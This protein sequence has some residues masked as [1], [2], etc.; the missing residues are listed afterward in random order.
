M[1]LE[2]H[3]PDRKTL[4]NAIGE[5]LHEPVH[6]DGAP[7]MTYSIGPVKVERDASITCDDTD[8][9]AALTPF[10][11]N[12]GWLPEAETNTGQEVSTTETNT[13]QAADTTET[14][15]VN[16]VSIPLSGFTPQSAANLVRLVYTRQDLLNAMTRG[17]TIFVDDEVI[18]LLSDRPPE[19]MDD[20]GTLLDSEAAV[21]MLRGIGIADGK[22]TIDFPFSE[23]RPTDWQH[24][25]KLM[26]ALADKARA[27][28]RVNARRIRP[29]DAE[30]KYFCN[31]LLNQLGFG[32]AEHKELRSVLL[33][34]LT[35]Y[36]AF[37]NREKMAAHRAKYGGKRKAEEESREDTHD[38]AN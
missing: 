20:L 1:R 7:S 4:A 26:F 30:M 28:T 31:S 24:Y 29:Y 33:G 15:T 16:S 36:A 13:A 3:S 32:G 11:Q 35:G 22:L 17:D 34:H 6:Y 14:I 19:S 21:G 38:E 18:S 2:T 25:A 8:V 5:W 9:W 10:F 12:Y 27:A 37:R 23:E